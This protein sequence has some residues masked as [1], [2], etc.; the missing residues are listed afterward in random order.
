M[1]A[2]IRFVHTLNNLDKSEVYNKNDP[3]FPGFYPH[4]DYKET[5]EMRKMLP[6]ELKKL[7]NPSVFVENQS[8]ARGYVGDANEARI[9]DDEDELRDKYFRAKWEFYVREKL[10]QLKVTTAD[11]ERTTLA[12]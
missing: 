12:H 2:Q 4:S 7:Y 5:E 6:E 1:M 9:Q 3:M 11:I 10:N 8:A